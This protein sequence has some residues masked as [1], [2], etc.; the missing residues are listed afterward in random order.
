MLKYN[1]DYKKKYTPLLEKVKENKKSYTRKIKHK[2]KLE[3]QG[4]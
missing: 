3:E 2:P 4:I 1:D